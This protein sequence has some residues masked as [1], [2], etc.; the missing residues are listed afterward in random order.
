[1]IVCFISD[2]KLSHTELC[3]AATPNNENMI[4]SILKSEHRA[5]NK[6]YIVLQFIGSGL[7]G[8]P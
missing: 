8:G 1:M 6:N 3:S 4:T 5:I 7:K 2:Y